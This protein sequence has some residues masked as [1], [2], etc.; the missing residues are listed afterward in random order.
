M[1]HLPAEN[2]IFRTFLMFF[3]GYGLILFNLVIY[4]QQIKD[5][6]FGIGRNVTGSKA[7]P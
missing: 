5:L 3:G 7:L 2:L 1:V 6:L 4:Y